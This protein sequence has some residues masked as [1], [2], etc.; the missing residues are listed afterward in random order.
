MGN[1]LRMSNV[2]RKWRKEVAGLTQIQAAERF[3]VSQPTISKWEQG[4]FAPE[5]C[6]QIHQVT[7]IPLHELRPDIYP[8]PQFTQ[9]SEAA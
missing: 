5:Q 1:I 8:K 4:K 7:G 9:A 6:P 2:F 3:D